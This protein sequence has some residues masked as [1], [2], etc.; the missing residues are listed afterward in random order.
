MMIYQNKK[1]LVEVDEIL[2]YLPEEEL[3][4]IPEDIRKSIYENKDEEYIWLYDES[5]PLK[6]Q[7]VSGDAVA[8]LSYLFMEYIYNNE[9]KELMKEIFKFNDKQ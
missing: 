9:Q 4:K 3:K 1:V 2:R 7:N 8:I 5:K 6:K